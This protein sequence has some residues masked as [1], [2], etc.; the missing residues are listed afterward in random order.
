VDTVDA[1]D[2]VDTVDTV[3]IVD[4]VDTHVN[5]CTN[6]QPFANQSINPRTR[7]YQTTTQQVRVEHPLSMAII[8]LLM[9]STTL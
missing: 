2:T 6:H 4:T 1:I 7:Q 5:T 9:L 8:L 3:D